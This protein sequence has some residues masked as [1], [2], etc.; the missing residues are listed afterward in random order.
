MRSGFLFVPLLAASLT[1]SAQQL[2]ESLLVKQLSHERARVE[3]LLQQAREQE[4][5]AR[6]VLKQAGDKLTAADSEDRRQKAQE[7]VIQADAAVKRWRA[8]AEFYQRWLRKVDRGMEQAK[9]ENVAAVII[10]LQGEVERL[11]LADWET[12]DGQMPFQAGDSLRTGRDGF[13]R[14]FLADGG[15]LTVGAESELKLNELTPERSTYA[16]WKGR[17]HLLWEL[18]TDP[19]FHFKRS[20]CVRHGCGGAVLGTELDFHVLPDD[21]CQITV[22]AGLVEWTDT[23]TGATV[24]VG[25]GERILVR[26]GQRLGPPVPVDLSQFDRWWEQSPA[27][28]TIGSSGVLER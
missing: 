8:L 19:N 9:K 20:F 7:A 6:D 3:G 28:R 14:A 4:S 11:S 16:I 26:L 24:R 17:I 27:S 5:R 13:V 2:P 15:Q 22:L 12:Y 18:L 1:T 10:D 21:S 23:A 25:L